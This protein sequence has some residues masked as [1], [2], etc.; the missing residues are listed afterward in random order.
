MEAGYRSSGVRL[1]RLTP[2][3]IFFAYN[4][5]FHTVVILSPCSPL[6]KSATIGTEGRRDDADGKTKIIEAH[7]RVTPTFNRLV[8]GSSPTSS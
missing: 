2:E 6:P 7:G 5:I 4:E 8:V 3:L 1:C